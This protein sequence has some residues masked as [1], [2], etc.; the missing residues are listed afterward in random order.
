MT[1]RGS[2]GKSS[3]GVASGAAEGCSGLLGEADHLSDAIW[4]TG[5]NLA[6][7]ASR[8]ASSTGAAASLG[9]APPSSWDASVAPLLLMGTCPGGVE[10]SAEKE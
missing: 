7:L 4:V 10:G 1:G 8:A 5:R 6:V 9:P 3:M 2:P